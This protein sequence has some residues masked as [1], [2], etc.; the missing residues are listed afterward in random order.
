MNFPVSP[1]WAG[2]E[3]YHYIDES[4]VIDSTKRQKRQNRYLSQT[5][6][7]SGYTDNEFIS[8]N[9]PGFPAQE[10]A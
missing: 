10:A 1:T 5:E 6:V 3:P 8:C 2:L 7:H 9:R 4:Q